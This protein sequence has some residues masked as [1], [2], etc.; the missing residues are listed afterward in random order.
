LINRLNKEIYQSKKY[1]F[2]NYGL[3]NYKSLIL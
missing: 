3:N 2:L 1:P